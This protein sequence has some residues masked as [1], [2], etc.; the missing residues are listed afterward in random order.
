MDST[1]YEKLKL[2]KDEFLQVL[3]MLAET[4]PHIEISNN[5]INYLKGRE[6]L[7]ETTYK[8]LMRNKAVLQEYA[9]NFLRNED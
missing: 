6:E 2:T 9:N 3:G 5:I 1:I 7:S 8:F 4:E